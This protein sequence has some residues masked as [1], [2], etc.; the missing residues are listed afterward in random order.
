[1]LLSVALDVTVFNT[2][3]NCSW[4]VPLQFWGGA[5]KAL[6]RL[7]WI[8]RLFFPF[9]AKEKVCETSFQFIL[10]VMQI[11]IIQCFQ[12]SGV[13]TELCVLKNMSNFHPFTLK[14]RRNE[15]CQSI[16]VCLQWCP[17]SQ[18]YGERMKFQT[19]KAVTI[20]PFWTGLGQW[21]HT[22]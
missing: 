12:K 6:V 18:K 7:V 2:V 19:E 10:T 11:N 21:K 17:S 13:V 9:S 15:R 8:G 22:M 14:G 16:P 4:A 20:F 1:M 3:L 5:F